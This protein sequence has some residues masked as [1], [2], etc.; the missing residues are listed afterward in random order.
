MFNQ[1]MFLGC[2]SFA[3]FLYLFF[4]EFFRN[5]FGLEERRKGEQ[6]MGVVFEENNDI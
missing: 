3:V 2:E 6:G 1:E 4:L 5:I